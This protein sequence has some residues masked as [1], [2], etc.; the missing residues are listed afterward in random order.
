VS[1]F[2]AVFTVLGLMGWVFSVTDS[3]NQIPLALALAGAT[4]G[5]PIALGVAILKHRLYQVDVLIQRTL[6]YG[7][8]SVTLLAVYVGSVMVIQPLLQALIG[9]ESDFAVMI[10]T[11]LVAVLFGPLHDRIRRVMDRRFFRSQ[12]DAERIIETFGTQLSTEVDLDRLT[13]RLIA[14]VYET[15]QPS[16]VSLWLVNRNMVHASEEQD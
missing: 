12:Y 2:I 4:L 16:Q 15:A 14:V 1:V 11:L 3:E 13:A 5:I 6:I 10:S 9:H 7:V 8:L